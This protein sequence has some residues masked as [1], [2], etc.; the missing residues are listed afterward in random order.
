[1][2]HPRSGECEAK[3]VALHLVAD[4]VRR[5][6]VARVKLVAAKRDWHDLVKLV[7]EWVTCWEGVIDWVAAYGARQ[8]H[9]LYP[10]PELAPPGPVAVVAARPHGPPKEEGA[11]PVWLD[12]LG[13]ISLLLRTLLITR[14]SCDNV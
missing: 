5:L 10:R 7:A 9:G 2:R 8:T 6:H 14:D 11:E 3:P 1:M 13:Y 4:A 12:P